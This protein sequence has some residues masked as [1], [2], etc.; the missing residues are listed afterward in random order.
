VLD[1]N[2][3]SLT[4]LVNHDVMLLNIVTGQPQLESGYGYRMQLLCFHVSL[5]AL[6][7]F[8]E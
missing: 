1:L 7:L 6:T 3:N 8:V 4:P 5:S 2:I